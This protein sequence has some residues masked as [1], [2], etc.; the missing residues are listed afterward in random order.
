MNAVPFKITPLTPREAQV[1]KLVLDGHTYRAV[2]KTLGIS[3]RTV[4]R[5]V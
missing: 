5:N 1:V 4:K 2:D 3:P